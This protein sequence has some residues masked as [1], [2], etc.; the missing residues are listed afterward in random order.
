[1]YLLGPL[2]VYLFRL[3]WEPCWQE[4]FPNELVQNFDRV[5]AAHEAK[6][7]DLFNDDPQYKEMLNEVRS[8][9]AAL[10]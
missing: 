1:M 7:G 4:L 3:R 10:L 9:C 6:Q 8:S 2:P 5:Y